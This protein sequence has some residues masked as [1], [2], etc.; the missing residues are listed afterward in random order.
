MKFPAPIAQVTEKGKPLSRVKG[1][2]ILHKG[3][4]APKGAQEL[5]DNCAVLKSGTYTFKIDL[6]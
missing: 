6:E 3:L 4:V 5:S 1:V 2:V